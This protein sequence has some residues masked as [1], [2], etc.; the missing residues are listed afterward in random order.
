VLRPKLDPFTLGLVVLCVAWTLRAKWADLTY[1]EAGALTCR[2]LWE[3]AYQRPFT[4]M[5]LH[6][7]GLHGLHLIAN[8]LSLLVVGRVIER[9]C[10]AKILV[11][12]V[13]GGAM[14]GFGVSM[15]ADPDPGLA[16]MG[17]SGGIAGLVGLLFAVEW[18]A[19][20]GLLDFLRQRNTLLL[21]LFLGLSFPLALW[22][23]GKVPG[24]QVDHAGHGGGFAF[25]IV[26]GLALYGRRA[27]RPRLGAVTGIL[28][29]VLPVAYASHPFLDPGYRY[30]RGLRAYRAGDHEAA[31]A[32]CARALELDPDSPSAGEAKR[33]LF[34]HYLR[35]AAANPEDPE[36]RKLVGAARALGVQ[37]PDPWLRFAEAAEKAGRFEDAYAAWREAAALLPRAEAWRPFAR[38][39]LLLLANEQWSAPPPGLVEHLVTVAQGAARGLTGGLDAR[40]RV[41]LEG[42]IARAASLAAGAGAPAKG[43]ARELSALYRTLA[44][45]AVRD[46][47]RP[48]YRLQ[49]ARWLWRSTEP[50]VTD[51]VKARFKAAV[52]EGALYGDAGT[53][54]AAEAWFLERGL[55]VPAPDLEG[56]EGGG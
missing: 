22:V 37:D 15:V 14:A 26:T 7:L 46:E 1:L 32:E 31:A 27:A 54:G 30:W 49:S 41:E 52:T 44:E 50:E 10:G 43:A 4:A 20:R 12:F 6:H 24:L 5:L 21:L 45:N 34:S 51:D 40:S 16:R 33:V 13:V 55:P 42:A 8:A 19:S 2:L 17:I 25:G 56:E 28:L 3:G 39:L 9:A 47:S 11:G 36:A 53:R 48:G 29:A 18:A 35:K 23:E 38:A